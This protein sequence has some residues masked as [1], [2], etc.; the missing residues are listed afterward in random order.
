M[1]ALPLK[2]DIT[3]VGHRCPLSGIAPDDQ[4]HPSLI[5]ID[6]G[7]TRYR[8]RSVGLAQL[9]EKAT[10]RQSRRCLSALRA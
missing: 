8:L 1:S 4:A 7:D 10:S 2:T 9:I 5:A 6:P 3:H